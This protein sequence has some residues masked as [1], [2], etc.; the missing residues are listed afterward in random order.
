MDNVQVVD[1]NIKRLLIQ[2]T[3]KDIVLHYSDA[4]LSVRVDDNKLDE[5]SLTRMRRAMYV[6]TPLVV[7]HVI[8]RQNK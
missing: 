1:A 5:L 7:N 3:I 8:D 2:L 6:V 4:V